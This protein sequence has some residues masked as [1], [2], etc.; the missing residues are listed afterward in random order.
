MGGHSDC[1]ITSALSWCQ[2][3]EQGTSQRTLNMEISHD[4]IGNRK[5]IFVARVSTDRAVFV[6]SLNFKM[7][8]PA[9]E[10]IKK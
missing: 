10:I 2:A 7:M 4:E 8:I 1:D 5:C 3:R 6:A 9:T